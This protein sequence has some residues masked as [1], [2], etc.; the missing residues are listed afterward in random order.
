VYL[1]GH[2]SRVYM[3]VRGQD[4]SVTM[5]RYLIDRISNTPNI[6]VLTHTELCALR[7]DRASGLAGAVWRDRRDGS[8]RDCDIRNLFRKRPRPPGHPPLV[9]YHD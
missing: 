3:L 6:E 4:L 5:S 9:A 7:G 2:A 8:Q 1:A